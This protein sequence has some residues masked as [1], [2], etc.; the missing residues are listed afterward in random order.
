LLPEIPIT[1]IINIHHPNSSSN[2]ENGSSEAS[3]IQVPGEKSHR[4]LPR[5]SSRG[6]DGFGHEIGYIREIARLDAEVTKWKS[7]CTAERERAVKEFAQK[8]QVID[9]QGKKLLQK[10]KQIESQKGLLK[11]YE[12]L[13]TST[14]TSQLQT[15]KIKQKYQKQNDEKD[16]TIEALEKENRILK[17]DNQKYKSLLAEYEEKSKE[18]RD[19]SRY[20]DLENAL[21]KVECTIVGLEERQKEIQKLLNQAGKDQER[22]R[23]SPGDRTNK[24]KPLKDNRD[25]IKQ[26]NQEM[27]WIASALDDAESKADDYA[28]KIEVLKMQAGLQE[29]FDPDS[30]GGGYSAPFD[31]SPLPIP[32]L[33]DD[34]SL[35]SQTSGS[36]PFSDSMSTIIFDRQTPQKGY[37]GPKD[38]PWA[39]PVQPSMEMTQ[40]KTMSASR[41]PARMGK[42]PPGR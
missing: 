6:S 15:M 40:T 11:D 7:Q 13:E 35:S 9:D 18:A 12:C 36:P 4:G 22:I 14:N 10:D 26:L 21:R 1:N 17:E 20:S 25:R 2:D 5:G 28:K 8:Q 30:S 3:A 19:R 39:Y 27:E 41:T 31:E 37:S 32:E 16:K 23:S 29:E 42:T 33:V 38:A 34:R 24:S